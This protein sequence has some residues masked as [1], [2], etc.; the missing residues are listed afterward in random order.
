MKD[1]TLKQ[2]AKIISLFDETPLE[3]IQ[4]ILGSGFL[5]D[6]RDG[7]IDRVNRDELRKLLGLKPLEPVPES[8]LEFIGTVEVLATTEKFVARDN[9]VRDV[10]KKAR[11]KISYLGGNFTEKFIGKIEE[12]FAGGILRYRKLRKSSVDGPIITELGGEQKAETTLAEIFALME[13]QGNGQS[14]SLLTNGY[15]N[16]FYIRDINGVL[17]AVSCAWYGA[18]WS[19]FAYSV[20]SPHGWHAGHQV[21][22]RNSSE[23][24]S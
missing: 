20:E 23:T 5:A 4:A 12:P 21:F 2:A 22:S 9:F 1:A 24:Q 11:V 19:V 14:G 6:L 7:D 3:Q 18:G 17:W 8:L 15:A 13:R 16:I 10:S